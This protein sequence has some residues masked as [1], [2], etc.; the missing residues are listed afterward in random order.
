MLGGTGL[1]TYVMSAGDG[2]EEGW[3]GLDSRRIMLNGALTTHA[4]PLPAPVP[5]TGS[6]LA[7][8]PLTITFIL[9]SGGVEACE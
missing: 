9:G 4:A 3:N 7:A 1:A 8:A 2:A 5:L 6:M